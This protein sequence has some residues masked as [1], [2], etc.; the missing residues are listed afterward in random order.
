MANLRTTADIVDAVLRRS[1]EPTGGTSPYETDAL[2]YVQETHFNLICGGEVFELDVDEDWSWAR[3]KKPIILTLEPKYE[4]GTLAVTNGSHAITFSSGPTASKQG[5]YLKVD[6][7]RTYYR[8]ASHAAGATAAE[9][10][11]N[12]LGTTGAA[13]N[14]K[15]IK[16][17]YEL[18][19]S[20][21]EITAKNNK[22]DFE[23]TASTEL[24]ATLTNGTYTP[25]ELA[26]EVKTQLDSA[27]AS[28]YTISYDTN[29]RK[30]TLASDRAG[31]GGTF[32]LLGSSGSNVE[33]SAFPDLGFDDE[34]V[35]DS[36]SHTGT[37]S[38]GRIGRVA[39]P[40]RVYR[41]DSDDNQI[42]NMP[43]NT[44][45][46]KWPL[47]NTEQGVPNYFT[48]ITDD[49]EGI[50]EI[51][52][53]KYPSEKTRIEVFVIEAPRDL[54]DN[55]AS[56]PLVPRKYVNLL[57]YGAAY[58]LCMDKEDDKAQ[59]YLGMAQAKYRAMQ[60][61]YKTELDYS[62]RDFGNIV[63]QE[64]DMEVHAGKLRY[65][66]TSDGVD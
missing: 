65:G 57:E 2:R 16:L 49:T 5:W 59:Q 6:G 61:E 31:G 21:I 25:A 4:T 23:E 3:R 55:T 52:F 22:I 46:R 24:T 28:T 51:R 14:F 32:K 41:N 40:V 11:G 50:T 19:P 48:R 45:E 1:G 7:D 54:K 13:V 64:R 53:N 29:T 10:D 60:N 66:Y 36:A 17:D 20:H 42:A 30:F 27:G 62:G 9:L 33:F 18:I 8:I 44:F 15:L 56:I 58:K 43:F 35:A 37:Y 38:L 63:A 47:K 39:A 12:Y 34:D 26:T